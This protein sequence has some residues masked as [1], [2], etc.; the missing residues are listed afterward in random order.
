M[1]DGIKCVGIYV[2]AG[3]GSVVGLED[4]TFIE[5]ER[6]GSEGMRDG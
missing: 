3:D 1:L 4:G 5:G 2:G 6:D